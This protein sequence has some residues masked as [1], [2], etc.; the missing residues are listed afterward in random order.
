MRSCIVDIKKAA[1][2]AACGVTHVFAEEKEWEIVDGRYSCQEPSP[3]KVRKATLDLLV[4]AGLPKC[5]VDKE[6][7]LQS[8]DSGDTEDCDSWSAWAVFSVAEYKVWVA[9]YWE[10]D[11]L[12]DSNDWT[13]GQRCE[14]GGHVSTYANRHNGHNCQE[15]GNE[16]Q[17]KQQRLSDL[18][19]Q[20][21]GWH[22]Y[23]GGPGRPFSHGPWCKVSRTRILVKTD[24]GLDV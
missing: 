19:L 12:D 15:C 11:N 5:L 22:A 10:W 17:T 6:G 14:C 23:D 20:L 16:Y 8:T 21:T 9:A 1:H 24:G 4:E 18:A 3:A 7:S 13:E 2:K